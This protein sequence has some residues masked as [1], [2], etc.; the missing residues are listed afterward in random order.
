MEMIVVALGVV[1]IL[2]TT[3]ALGVWVFAALAL[4]ARRIE[5]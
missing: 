5:A 3:L 2:L 1:A 4:A